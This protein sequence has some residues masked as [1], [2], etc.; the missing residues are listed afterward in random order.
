MLPVRIVVPVAALAL[1]LAA[2]L[3]R[4]AGPLPTLPSS[5][6]L[7]D[8]AAAPAAESG[9]ATGTAVPSAV[10]KVRRGVVLIEQGG[11]LVGFGTVLGGDGRILTSLS[12]I[13]A[14]DAADIQYADG[15]RIHAKV[16]QK[17][18]MWDLALL[19]PSAVHWKDGLSASDVDP[20]STVLRAPVPTLAGA[21][22][23][24]LPVHFKGLTDALSPKGDS[25][26]DA[27]DIEV[28]HA[29]PIAGAPILDSQATVVGVLVRACK[30][31]AA[32]GPAAK[33]G[34]IACAP[35]LVGAP[36]SALKAFLSKAPAAPG[37]WLGIVGQ[38]DESGSVH[39]VRVQA[40][41]PESPAQKAGLKSAENGA[42]DRI[43]AVDGAPVDTPQKLA[44]AIGKHAPGE[45][46]KLLVLGG[47]DGEHPAAFHDVT[48]VLRAAP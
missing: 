45:S 14:A 17:D 20:A 46:V 23:I 37:P 30:L 13:G 40:V 8:A 19:S 21:K 1:S 7:P 18:P 28:H 9:A 22:P 32:T 31:A 6:P 27:L 15:A 26:L 2:P 4:A 11:R 41:A 44:D 33:N 25:L 10:D 24:A 29:L 12:A 38:A 35:T 34:P 47:E 5:A 48:V 36:V 43:I 42:G 3:A 39:G 16:T